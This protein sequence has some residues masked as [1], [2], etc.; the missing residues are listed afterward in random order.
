MSLFPAYS[1]GDAV[2]WKYNDKDIKKDD[3][4]GAGLLRFKV[5]HIW[6]GDGRGYDA[7]TSLVT[8]GDHIVRFIYE[9]SSEFRSR[10]I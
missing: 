2:P 8:S 3:A 9:D 1:D 6:R 4:L 5:Y 10:P 7:I